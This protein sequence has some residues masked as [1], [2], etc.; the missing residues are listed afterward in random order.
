MFIVHAGS[1]CLEKMLASRVLACHDSDVLLGTSLEIRNQFKHTRNV[2]SARDLSIDIAEAYNMDVLVACASLRAYD[3]HMLMKGNLDSFTVS[4]IGTEF[5]NLMGSD[6]W[7]HTLLSLRVAISR[8]GNICNSFTECE[9]N[10]D[11][12]SIKTM[13]SPKSSGHWLSFNWVDV[14]GYELSVLMDD[15]LDRLN[16]T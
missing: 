7:K 12:S 10:M 9:V 14:F 2:N 4:A 15:M 3:D 16:T 13:L 5:R 6:E 1:P 8:K 11:V